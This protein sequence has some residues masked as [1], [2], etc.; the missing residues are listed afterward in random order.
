VDAAS[1]DIAEHYFW[2]DDTKARGLL[3]WSPRDTGETLHDTVQHI[4]SR[5]AP[6]N[7]PGTYGRLA[8]LRERG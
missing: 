6:G 3:G 1:V 8:E 5:M 4:V 2:L 7:L